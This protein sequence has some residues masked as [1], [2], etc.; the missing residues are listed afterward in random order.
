VLARF[1]SEIQEQLDTKAGI[2]LRSARPDAFEEVG[3]DIVRK[4]IESRPDLAV[5]EATSRL[6]FV[7]MPF[8]SRFDDVYRNLIAPAGQQQGLTVLRADEMSGAGVII[9]QIRSAI[10]QS[11]LCIADLTG[12]NPN[13]LYELGFAQALGKPLI[14]VAEEASRLPFDLAH[15]RVILYGADLRGAQPSLETA[16]AQAVSENRLEEAARLF[17]MKQYRG[18]IAASAVV[19]EQKLRSMLEGR[20]SERLARMTLGKM[21]SELKKLGSVKAP[22]HEQ[23]SDVVALRN[24]AVHELT[25]PSR[26]EA[27]F[28]LS[29]VREFVEKCR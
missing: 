22:E 7:M 8:G 5:I 9:E 4:G 27:E 1:L 23:L 20:P 26:Q 6:C 13:V 11:R 19:L 12:S 15:Y 3:T 14:M 17:D 21:L 25:E 29:A 2:T 10:Q 16:M 18:A 24:R 28:V